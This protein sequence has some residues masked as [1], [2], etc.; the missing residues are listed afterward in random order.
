MAQGG[1]TQRGLRAARRATGVMG[2]EY[3]MARFL[4]KKQD[5]MGVQ[6]REP[7]DD[8]GEFYHEVGGDTKF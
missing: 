8:D 2:R 1:C 7:E 6:C 3:K 5:V 4:L